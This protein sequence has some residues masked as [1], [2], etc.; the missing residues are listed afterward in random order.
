MRKKLLMIGFLLIISLTLSGCSSAS[1]YYRNGKKYF[2]SGNYEE[3]ADNF[4]AAIVEN[5]NRAGYYIDYGMTLIVLGKYEEAIEQFDKIYMEKNIILIKENNKR[6][7]R[8]KGIAYFNMR[9]Y[10]EAITQ[11]NA[12]L[13]IN[14]LSE[15]DMDI[16]YY[17]GRALTTIGAF[18]E[19]KDVY[20]QIIDTFGN[21]AEALFGRA[22]ALMKLK[23]YEESL[24]DYD[25][26][27]S[28]KPRYYNYYFGKYDLMLE[29]GDKD[30]AAEVLAQAAAIEAKSDEDRYQQAK[31]HYYQELYD[32]ALAELSEGF[33]NGFVEAYFYI[34]EVYG[35][36]KDYSTAIYYYEK[37]MGEVDLVSPEVY[38]QIAG[39]LMKLEEYEQAIRY[40]EK[41]LAYE[42]SPVVQLLRKN[43]IVAYENLGKF[44][45][46][47]TKIREYLTLYPRDEE[48][49]REEKF[50]KIRMQDMVTPG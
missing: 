19:A 17:K 37:Y 36:R 31:V 6:A 30:G 38:N 47:L 48:A 26:A 25:L 32:L 46:A 27:I 43:E 14:V 23:D 49:I 20:T 22:G 7:L 42:Y 12:G 21:K 44:D 24:A 41:G 33:A 5:P 45:I 9:K 50:L 1:G 28:L 2:I 4:L 13:E 29:T 8:G 35:K 3:A 10:Q 11:F 16:L 15:L 18:E 40:L 34:G 39:C